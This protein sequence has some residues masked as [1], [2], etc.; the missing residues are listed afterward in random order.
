[1]ALCLVPM[2]SLT[3]LSSSTFSPFSSSLSSPD[4][5]SLSSRPNTWE[6]SNLKTRSVSASQFF[7]CS[8]WAEFWA[9]NGGNKKG[10]ETVRESHLLLNFLKENPHHILVIYTHGI[11]EDLYSTTGPTP[12]TCVHQYQGPISYSCFSMIICLNTKGHNWLVILLT[13]VFSS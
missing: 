4:S 11:M 7:C 1:M 10:N 3:E 5:S 12:R 8:A 2:F 6:V 9:A 13:K